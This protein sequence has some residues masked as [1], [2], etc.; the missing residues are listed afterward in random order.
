MIGHQ[1]LPCDWRLALAF[2][3]P[4][5][6]HGEALALTVAVPSS[7]IASAKASH[8]PALVALRPYAWTNARS[9]LIN[10]VG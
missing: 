5:K 6:R 1:I 2:S 3:F 7:S 8:S 9:A 4:R 10:C